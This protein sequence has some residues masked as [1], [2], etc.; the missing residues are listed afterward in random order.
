M[1][2]LR[3]ERGAL[4]ADLS[5]DHLPAARPWEAVRIEAAGLG[6]WSAR[7]RRI[8]AGAG[9][10][11]VDPGRFRLPYDGHFL[12]TSF[13]GYEFT[14]GSAIVQ[15]VTVPPDALEVDGPARRATLVAPLD[16]TIWVIPAPTAWAG[17]AVWRDLDG[18]RPGDGVA[19]LRGR[20]VFDCWGGRYADA[21]AALERSFRY[22]LTDAVVIWHQWQ[23]W[24]YDFRLPDI[25]PP[26]PEFG[27]EA[28]FKALAG[29]CRMHGVLFAP[30]DNYI[31]AYPDAAGFDLADIAHAQD[32]TPVKAWFNAWRKA[33]SFRFRPDRFQ[34]FLE[35]NLALVRAGASPSAYFV[36][37]FASIGLYDGWTKE[38]AFF[39]RRLTRRAWGEAFDRIRQALD[40]APTISESG[41]DALVGHLDGATANHLRVE[42]GAAEGPW[43]VWRTP[44][45][46][47]ERIPWLDFVHHA[48]FAVHGA[49]YEDRYAAGLSVAT[50]GIYSD[51]YLC[52][53]VLDGHPPMVASPFGRE[54]VRVGWLLGPYGRALAGRRIEAVEFADGNLHRQVVRWEGGGVV[55]VNR[56]QGDWAVDGRVLPPYGFH[57]R[58]P[59]GDGV[60]EAALERRHGIIVEWADDP[61]G[62]YVNTHPVEAR[63]SVAVVGPPALDPGGRVAMRLAWRAAK[64]TDQP[65]R[66]FVH[67]TDAA[68]AIRFQADHELPVSTTA[69]AGTITVRASTTVPARAQPGD[70]FALRAGLYAPAGA[71]REPLD[72]ADDGERRI[73]LGTVRLAGAAGR[74]TGWR[75]EPRPQPADPRLDRM[76]TTGT[77]I[78]F[79]SVTTAGAARIT[80]SGS[81]VLVTPLP[82]SGPMTLRLQPARLPGH[83]ATL[84]EATALAEDGTPLSVR[85][86]AGTP[87]APV[88]ACDPGVFAYLLR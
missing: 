43:S 69:W 82:G 42:P 11:L 62:V 36:D 19:R 39:D 79:G 7:P 20:M 83:P 68:G 46:D 65:L 73:I 33:Q 1:I 70:R 66:A 64:P 2:A 32:R 26:N 34:P 15:A 29:A 25:W 75:W 31:D 88:L 81:G 53:E 41:D 87:P 85:P 28:E 57:A 55:R 72:G 47:A 78:A 5:L 44:C 45:A 60:V 59:A 76:N 52:T 80:R 61:G 40:G 50:H 8:F 56:G 4:R 3:V 37:V 67:F 18:R 49:G 23:R 12:A 6:P 16:Q 14:P 58:I 77:P 48:R 35:R 71:W 27:T 30:H 21:R 17:A 54:V 74:V 51:D 84:R 9:N 13:A 10:V 86:L 63:I 38:G 24:G 22:R